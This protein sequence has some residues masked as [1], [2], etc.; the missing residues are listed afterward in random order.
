MKYRLI[1]SQ[2][3]EVFGFQGQVINIITLSF[4]ILIVSTIYFTI[5]PLVTE[6]KSREYFTQLAGRGH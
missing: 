2:S 4:E 5:L 6:I 3:L 1:S